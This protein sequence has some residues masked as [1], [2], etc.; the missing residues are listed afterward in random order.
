ML[1]KNLQCGNANVILIVTSIDLSFICLH[2]YPLQLVDEP[3][4]R[5]LECA[6]FRRFV[7][8]VAQITSYRKTMATTII[9]DVFE[10]RGELPAAEDANSYS[11]ILGRE[12]WVFRVGVHE[13]RH[14]RLSVSLYV[15]K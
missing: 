6:L 8:W 15:H 1:Y 11:T 5:V 2:L 4:H 3:L 14:I 7:D 12:L 13:Q 10:S 9:I